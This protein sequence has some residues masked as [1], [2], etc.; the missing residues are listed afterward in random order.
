M[1][2]PEQNYKNANIHELILQLDRSVVCCLTFIQQFLEAYIRRF[3]LEPH[4][5]KIFYVNKNTLQLL[6]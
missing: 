6:H 3:I 2:A 1:K 4:E 5:N